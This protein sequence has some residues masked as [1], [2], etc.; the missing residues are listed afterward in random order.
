MATKAGLKINSLAV[1][2]KVVFPKHS[3]YTHTNTR[4]AKGAS[5]VQVAGVSRGAFGI[6]PSSSVSSV[7][8]FIARVPAFL[9]NL[10]GGT[11]SVPMA[12]GGDQWWGEE[13]VAVVTGGNKGIGYEIA[14]ILAAEDVTCILTARS[15]ERGKIAA[16][17]IL[18]ETGK[19]V[20][21]HKLDITDREDCVRLAEFVRSEY[22]HLDIL[23]N[24]AGF[25][26]HGNI[27]G[28][29][30]AMTTIETNVAGTMNVCEAM[31]PVLNYDALHKA[32]IVNVCSMS[33]KT[34]LVAEPLRSQVTLAAS[35]GTKE[36][37]LALM[38]QFVDQVEDGTW[39]SNGWP[40][41]MYGVSK[42]GEATYTRVL[43][44]ELAAQ[45][46]LVSACCPGWCATDMS[47][48]SGRKTAAQGADTPVWLALAAPDSVSG[49][50]WSE[51]QR[52]AF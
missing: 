35:H 25:A 46:V 8:T 7:S 24:N 20:V 30:E 1:L 49:A 39:Q 16:A 9:R 23:V 2:R 15:E 26:Y 5:V 10:F 45:E 43:A 34:K 37:V 28:A 36:D 29:Q 52:Q 22:G 48:W 32:R 21:F 11:S 50:F 6:P 14:K 12:T 31:K 27:F 51:R 13:T 4:P 40:N 47:S 17:K 38:Q 44:R 42:L 18:A 41:T 19:S 33:G 3:R